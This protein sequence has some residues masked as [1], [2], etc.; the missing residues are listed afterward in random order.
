MAKKMKAKAKKMAANNNTYTKPL[1]KG[2]P[3][4]AFG[5]KKK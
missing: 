5:G 3:D 2:S 1:G 4:K